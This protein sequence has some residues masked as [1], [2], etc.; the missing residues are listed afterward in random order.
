MTETKV[1]CLEKDEE[2]KGGYTYIVGCYP[3]Q[4]IARQAM[5]K[6]MFY[7][8]VDGIYSDV[9]KP[10]SLEVLKTR[11]KECDWEAIEGMFR[12][13]QLRNDTPIKYDMSIHTLQKE[14]LVPSVLNPQ[15][16]Q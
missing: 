2:G 4:T 9:I 6:D 15:F 16:H 5:L 10:G 14:A 8:L 12:V 13:Y 3:N 11:Y 1:C 7:E